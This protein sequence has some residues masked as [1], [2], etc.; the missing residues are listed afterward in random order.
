MRLW[1]FLLATLLL[2]ALGR[3][4]STRK[5]DELKRDFSAQDGFQRF[6]DG[7]L[8]RSALKEPAVSAVPAPAPSARPSGLEAPP[9]SPARSLRPGGASVPAWTP[10]KDV[11]RQDPPSP[12]AEGLALAGVAMLGAAAF[13]SFGGAVKDE[14]GFEAAAETRPIEAAAQIPVDLEP[15][16]P[17]E[18]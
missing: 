9:L 15:L 5:V 4:E 7:S 14:P 17:A 10:T 1:A 6:V 12:L 3:A 18:N 8:S 2:P 16:P 13:R 11:G